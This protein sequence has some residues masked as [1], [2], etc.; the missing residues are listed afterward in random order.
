M[1]K[2]LHLELKKRNIAG[3]LGYRKKQDLPANADKSQL[4][5]HQ[6]AIANCSCA[7][8]AIIETA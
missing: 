3:Y 6:A 5:Q 1:E 7:L 4:K 2:T 8:P